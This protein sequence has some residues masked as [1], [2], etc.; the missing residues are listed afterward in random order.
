MHISSSGGFAGGTY[1]A[2]AEDQR[3]VLQGVDVRSPGAFG[4]APSATDNDVIAQLLQR[5]KLVTDGP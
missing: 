1:S 2:A 5:G 3:I 4:L